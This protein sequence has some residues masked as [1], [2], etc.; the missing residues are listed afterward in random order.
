MARGYLEDSRKT[1]RII[2]PYCHFDSLQTND[3]TS[4]R[5]KPE[6][7]TKSPGTAPKWVQILGLAKAKIIDCSTTLLGCE[8]GLML[9]GGDSMRLLCEEG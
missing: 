7:W 1:S 4:A 9:E 8:L 2:F 6:Q 3:I 5:A